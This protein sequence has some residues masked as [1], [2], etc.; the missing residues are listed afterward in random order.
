MRLLGAREISFE[1]DLADAGVFKAH[2]RLGAVIRREI[3]TPEGKQRMFM[4]YPAPSA[5]NAEKPE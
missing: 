3:T 2:L 5:E 4:E 1:V